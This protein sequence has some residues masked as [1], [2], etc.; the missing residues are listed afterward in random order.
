MS[1]QSW[2]KFDNKKYNKNK[3]TNKRTL[4]CVYLVIANAGDR[5]TN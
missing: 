4:W 2:Y 3:L 5:Q 1:K